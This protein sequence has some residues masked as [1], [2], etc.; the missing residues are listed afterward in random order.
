[1]ALN[2]FAAIGR[3]HRVRI[4]L[5][6]ILLQLYRLLFQILSG[7]LILVNEC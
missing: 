7:V 1:M 2:S 5:R 4:R 3:L 6:R